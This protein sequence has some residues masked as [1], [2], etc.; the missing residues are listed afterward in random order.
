M[1][2]TAVEIL[3]K[4]NPL[5]REEIE[6]VSEKWRKR[7]A[8]A[9][10]KWPEGGT[11]DATVCEEMEVMMKNHKLNKKGK[12]TIEKRERE[13]IILD[14]FKREGEKWRQTEQ[15]AREMILGAK[16]LKSSSPVVKPPLKIQSSSSVVQPPPY[17]KGLYPV[18]SGTVDVRGE[19][20]IDEESSGACGTQRGIDPT[21]HM[22]CYK[23]VRNLLPEFE[24][25]SDEDCNK[26][27]QE[28]RRE[29]RGKE[30]NREGSGEEQ[31]REGKGKEQRRE[32]WR[33]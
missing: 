11:F 32:G 25:D 10:T 31:S 24:S 23:G 19:V 6:K 7:T 1:G 13:R 15:T 9:G 3:I 33:V 14:M 4:S 16:K 28:Q 29:G 5:N 8:V 18:I 30:Q 12:K 2:P 21:I 17:N 26:N 27:L 22:D 20:T